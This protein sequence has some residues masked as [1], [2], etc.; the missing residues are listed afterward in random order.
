MTE[1]QHYMSTIIGIRPVDDAHISLP[2]GPIQQRKMIGMAYTL[3]SFS[4][5]LI[6]NPFEIN[7]RDE[8]EFIT[9]MLDDVIRDDDNMKD[10]FIETINPNVVIPT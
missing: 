8:I 1:H 5:D 7:D 4:R 9:D 6:N 10:D 2:S 3:N